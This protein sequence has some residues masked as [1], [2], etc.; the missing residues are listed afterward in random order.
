MILA[1]GGVTRFQAEILSADE[2]SR[3]RRGLRSGAVPGFGMVAALPRIAR[4]NRHQL[5]ARPYV[6]RYFI[7]VSHMMVT[8]V[9]PGPSCSASRRAAM[10]LQPVEVP[11]KRPS[12]V[13]SR[14]AI[15][16]ASLVDTLSI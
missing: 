12:S 1:G 2:C 4:T 11:A 16:I 14:K 10:T 9:A 6:L 5:S 13:A 3:N 8:I 15:A 7:P